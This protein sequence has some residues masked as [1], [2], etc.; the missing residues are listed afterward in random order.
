MPYSPSFLNAE[1]MS[2]LLDAAHGVTTMIFFVDRVNCYSVPWVYYLGS[3]N[4]QAESAPEIFNQCLNDSIV[5][6]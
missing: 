1:A 6:R 3:E 2:D 5:H 4:L